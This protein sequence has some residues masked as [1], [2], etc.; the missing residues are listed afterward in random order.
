MVHSPA[1]WM[2]VILWWGVATAAPEAPAAPATPPKRHGAAVASLRPDDLADFGKNPAPIRR[3]LASCLDL[4]TRD[5]GYLMGSADP[6]R[7]GMDCSGTIQFVLR[8]AGVPGV[9]RQ[10]DEQYRWV[11]E[12][13]AFR[14]VNARTAKTF[15][16]D[17][18]KPG[19]LLFWTGTYG[20]GARDP[21]VSH[22]MIYLGRT[23]ADGKPVMFGSSDGRVFRG[24]PRSGVSV[25]DFRFPKPGGAARFIGYAPIPGLK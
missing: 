23:R 20:T 2:A 15:E 24:V 19:D 17:A 25:F 4:T 9:P 14:A 8:Q 6:A 3:L 11:W 1:L 16:L 7:G 5:L 10:S 12:A 21:A 13:E 22:V 18:L